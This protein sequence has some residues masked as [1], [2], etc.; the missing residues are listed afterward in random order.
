MED[1]EVGS[2]AKLLKKCA[3]RAKTL[4][5]SN[6]FATGAA[7]MIIVASVLIGLEAN[8]TPEELQ[9]DNYMR[10]FVVMENLIYAFFVIELFLHMLAVEFDVIEYTSD[11]WNI[12]DFL[13]VVGSKMP[14][15]GAEIVV[16]RLVR[17]LR[18]LKLLKAFPELGV[19]V[20]ALIMGVSSISY[21]AIMIILSFYMFGILASTFFRQNDPFH[22]GRLHISM[23]SLFQIATLDNWGDIMFVNVYGC[24]VYP[25]R[26]TQTARQLSLCTSPHA[27]GA[28]AAIFFIIFVVFGAL[29]MLTL[30]VGVV[31]TSMDESQKHSL[32]EID[33]EKR[34]DEVCESAK[35]GSDLLSVYRRVFKMLDLDSSGCISVSELQIC[36]AAV[37]IEAD[38]IVIKEWVR[39]VDINSDG[40]IDL[41]E[42]ILVRFCTVSCLTFVLYCN[43]V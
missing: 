8:L 29:V 13:V 25:P 37:R 30:F 14:S 21:I 33:L 38:E 42:F 36:L 35:V 3:M 4:T 39:E 19:I 20:N 26:P 34:I 18:V 1:D 7:A 5:E 22:F 17:I 16:L 9:N 43:H 40:E 27:G 10:P 31:T 41:V 23:Y 11:R 32:V 12:F 24:D 6:Y 15:A 2:V 28:W